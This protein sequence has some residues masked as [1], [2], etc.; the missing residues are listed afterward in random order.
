VPV[1]IVL[2]AL[3][4]V[5]L[6]LVVAIPF[7]LVMRYRAGKARRLARG[8]VVTAN[9]VGLSISI[10]LFLAGAA[11]TSFW[12]RRAFVYGLGGIGAGGVLGILGLLVTRWEPRP[13]GLFFTPNRWLVLLVTL[14]VAARISFGVWR[15]WHTWHHGTGEVGWLEA[16][17]VAQSLAAG[18]IVLGYYLV[19]LL[20]LRRRLRAHAARPLPASSAAPARTRRR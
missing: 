4:G 6:F 2:L 9:L 20:G 15:A 3:L 10:V 8:W 5:V 14:V 16:F 7:S 18:A 19:Y 12:V 17:G 11:V 1:L 13:Q